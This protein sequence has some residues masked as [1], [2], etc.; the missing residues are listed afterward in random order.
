[1]SQKNILV[2]V[3]QQKSCD[4]LIDF[5]LQLKKAETDQLH[6]LHV[7]KDDWKY[8]GTLKQEDALE[9]L[10]DAAQSRG[11]QLT[12]LKAKDI[13][14]TLV[15]F[16]EAN[17]ITDFVMGESLEEQAQQNMIRRVQSKSK[18]SYRFSVIPLDEPRASRRSRFS[19]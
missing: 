11:A 17:Q 5:G 7:I 14:N 13:E 4:R 1:M 15:Q 3:T 10:F 9:Y 16:A 6:V 8:F 18:R 2:C 19:S 12:V